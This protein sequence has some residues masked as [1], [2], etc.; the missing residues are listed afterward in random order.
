MCV[1]NLLVLVSPGCGSL[2]V[3]NYPRVQELNPALTLVSYFSKTKDLAS[4][5]MEIPS[6]P[7]DLGTGR[8]SLHTHPPY[9]PIPFPLQDRLLGVG[10][11]SIDRVAAPSDF[12]ELSTHPSTTPMKTAFLVSDSPNILKPKVIFKCISQGPQPLLQVSLVITLWVNPDAQSE[13]VSSKCTREICQILNAGAIPEKQISR[14][15][16]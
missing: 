7:P 6:Q 3:R 9:T 13:K 1:G 12:T 15:R 11:R 14:A 4:P 10:R 8:V 16:T 5:H 2:C